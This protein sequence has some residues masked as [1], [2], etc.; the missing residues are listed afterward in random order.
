LRALEHA[1]RP[2]SISLSLSLS[3]SSS[4]EGFRCEIFQK[5]RTQY[6]ATAARPDR[7]TL[8]DQ[9]WI[10]FL[11]NSLRRRGYNGRKREPGRGRGE[12]GGRRG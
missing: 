3:L 8:P 4:A 2:S 5:G 9:N 6:E 12:G 11:V 7:V 1:V 10:T